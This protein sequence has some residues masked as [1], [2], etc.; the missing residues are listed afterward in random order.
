MLAPYERARLRRQA[1]QP[2]LG[3]ERDELRVELGAE[4][5]KLL[6]PYTGPVVVAILREELA[7]IQR[8]RRSICAG[9]A[10]AARI[11]CGLLEVVDVYVCVKAQQLLAQRDD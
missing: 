1:V 2:I 7:R 4:L 10:G 8:Q 3:A 5:V 9:R 11:H 6:A